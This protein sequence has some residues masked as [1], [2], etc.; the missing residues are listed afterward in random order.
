M[1]HSSRV[2]F[3]IR[4]W[5]LRRTWTRT[6]IK[7]G[8]RNTRNEGKI[9]SLILSSA[10]HTVKRKYTSFLCAAEYF[11]VASV[12]FCSREYV[13][14]EI[15][16]M[17]LMVLMLI[18]STGA[19]CS[20]IRM[21]RQRLCVAL[22]SRGDWCSL[23][24]LHKIQN[25]AVFLVRQPETSIVHFYTVFLSRQLFF[26]VACVKF[27]CLIFMY[28]ITNGY[29]PESWCFNEILHYV[30]TFCKT[31]RISKPHKLEEVTMLRSATANAG[32]RAG[33]LNGANDI[34]YQTLY[35]EDD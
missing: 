22:T 33:K 25:T 14:I 20:F 28:R 13:Y 23:I 9:T 17:R 11:E 1:F 15:F 27:K 3:N 32:P 4:L 26:T 7:L 34:R 2:V 24:S 8:P 18:I 21:R 31:K 30:Y 5:L 6:K 12:S 29:Y 35:M 10:W 16:V 19:V